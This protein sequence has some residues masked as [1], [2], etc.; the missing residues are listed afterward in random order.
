MGPSVGDPGGSIA[1]VA[2]GVRVDP[3]ETGVIVDR[4]IGIG[5]WRHPVCS[6]PAVPDTRQRNDDAR[7]SSATSGRVLGSVGGIQPGGQDV[8]AG[9]RPRRIP[10]ALAHLIRPGRSTVRLICLWWPMVSH[11]GRKQGEGRLCYIMRYAQPER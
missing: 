1:R 4:G 9:L 3:L 5:P 11:G 6:E 8:G 7:Q 10:P 2:S